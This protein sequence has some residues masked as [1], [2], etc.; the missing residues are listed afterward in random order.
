MYKVNAMLKYE[1]MQ[2]HPPGTIETTWSKISGFG[3]VGLYNS[4]SP[5]T[6]AVFSTPSLKAQMSSPVEP[7]M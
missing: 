7:V 4:N 1:G 6:T 2:K 3:E 5:A